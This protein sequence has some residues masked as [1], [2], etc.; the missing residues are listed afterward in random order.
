MSAGGSHEHAQKM[1]GI[2][3]LGIE[4]QYLVVAALRLGQPAG[5]MVLHGFIQKAH[6]AGR[7]RERLRHGIYPGN[8]EIFRHPKRSQGG[9]PSQMLLRSIARVRRAICVSDGLSYP[10]LDSSRKDAVSPL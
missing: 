6:Q 3:L 10:R 5:T 7:W 8:S 9:D 1:Q 4:R 2:R